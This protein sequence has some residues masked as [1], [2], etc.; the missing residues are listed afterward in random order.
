MLTRILFFVLIL[1]SWKEAAMPQAVVTRIYFL[2]YATLPEYTTVESQKGI[3][4]KHY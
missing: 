3:Y 1:Y 4:L 2:V